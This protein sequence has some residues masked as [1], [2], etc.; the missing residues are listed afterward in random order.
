MKCAWNGTSMELIRRIRYHCEALRYKHRRLTVGNLLPA[1]LRLGVQGIV[2]TL[3]NWTKTLHAQCRF[4]FN[5]AFLALPIRK[6]NIIHAKSQRQSTAVLA[7]L[8]RG[9]H[10]LSVSPKIE[11]VPRPPIR[12]LTTFFVGVRSSLRSVPESMGP[13]SLFADFSGCPPCRPR[14]APGPA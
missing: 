4:H 8:N 2:S 13:V 3:G 5:A 9:D 10:R 12:L 11:N 7:N 1:L 14:C 6:S